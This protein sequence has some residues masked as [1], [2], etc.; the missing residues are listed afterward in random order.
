VTFGGCGLNDHAAKCAARVSDEPHDLSK[1]LLPNRLLKTGS[2]ENRVQSLVRAAHPVYGSGVN[3]THD[4]R[5]T[6]E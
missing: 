4:P 5:S 3:F 2:T 1:P 6:I